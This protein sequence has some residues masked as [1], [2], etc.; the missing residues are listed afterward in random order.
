MMH[1]IALPINIIQHQIF[2]MK[3]CQIV[4]HVLLSIM[5]HIES[6]INMIQHQNQPQ[7]ATR[8]CT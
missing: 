5:H 4:P 6:K 2:G 1:H 8:I 7:S 3:T